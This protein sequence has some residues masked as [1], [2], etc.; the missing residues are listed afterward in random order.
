M[1]EFKRRTALLKK[2]RLLRQKEKIYS[3]QLI[4]LGKKAWESHIDITAYGNLQDIIATTQAQYGEQKK[5]IDALEIKKQETENQRKQENDSFESRRKQ[6]EEKKKEVDFRLDKEKK[7]LRDA[8]RDSN[9]SQNRLNY[10]AREKE[11]LRR[12]AADEDTSDIERAE[13]QKKLDAFVL[14]KEELNKK[15]VQTEDTIK[16]SNDKIMPIEEESGKL[17]KEIDE[18]RSQQKEVMRAMDESLSE[19]RE[20]INAYNSK[21]NELSKEQEGYFEQ[22][23]EKL[24]A[25][26]VGDDSVSEE[27]TDVRAT[28]NDMQVIKNKIEKLDRSETAGS[29]K[30]FWT[31]IGLVAASVIIIIT[32]II[33]LSSMFGPGDNVENKLTAPPMESEVQKSLPP[34]LAESIEKYRQ[35][36]ATSKEKNETGDPVMTIDDAMKKMNTVTGEMKKQSEQIQGTEIVVSDKAALTAALPTINGWTMTEPDY[37]KGSFAQLET[38]SINTTYTTPDSQKIEVNITD[39][40]TASVALQTWRIIVQMNLT[41]DDD[42][43]YQKITS[44]SKMPIIERYK[45]KSQKISLGFIFR[46]RYMIELKSKGRDIVPILKDLIPQFHLSK[47]Q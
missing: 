23:G 34:H 27:F 46:D 33:L 40:A 10:I 35:K 38:S 42:R 8:Q 30:A 31:L 3:Q 41:R 22:L 11:Q 14:E 2:K 21:L 25:G 39:T 15:I 17:Q 43:G 37:R 1:R 5:L 45:K 13:I 4:S 36:V 47:L 16:N 44:I 20:K 9:S 26:G 29:R 24:A 18:I 32:V 19:I 28:E 12:K 6:I 7:V